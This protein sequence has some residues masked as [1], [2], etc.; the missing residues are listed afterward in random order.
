MGNVLRFLTIA[1]CLCA[2]PWFVYALAEAIDLQAAI[3]AGE[4]RR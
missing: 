3:D 2:G 1:L 4:V